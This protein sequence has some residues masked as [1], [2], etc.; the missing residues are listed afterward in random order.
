MR[1][2]CLDH[3]SLADLEALELIRVAADAGFAAVSLFATPIPISRARNLVT[4]RAAR[5][6]VLAALRD[7]GLRVGIVEPFMLEPVVDWPMFEGLAGLAA[8]IGGTVNMLGMDDDPGRLRDSFGRLVEICRAAGVPAI[9]EAYAQSVVS[10]PALAL[11]LA[12]DLGPD[13]G[14]CVDTLH[15]IRSGGDWAT[16][17]ALPPERIRHVQLND[18]P[19]APPADRRREAAFARLLPGKGEFGLRALLPL[20]PDH[21]TVAVEAP[22]EAL[23][24]LPAGER[25]ARLMASLTVL[26]EDEDAA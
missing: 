12:G 17:A 23:A 20:L 10:T 16:V 19:R 5:A 25:A 26:Y 3:L 9:I 13:V 6:E 7:T 18:G 8:E 11:A 21:A 1:R 2:F 14:L 4:D 15:V 22:C 24:A